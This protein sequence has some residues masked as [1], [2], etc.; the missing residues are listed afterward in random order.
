MPLGGPCRTRSR[1][2]RVPMLGVAGPLPAEPWRARSAPRHSRT[3]SPAIAP[4]F[5]SPGSAGL[6][7][8]GV[9]GALGPA[10]RGSPNR[11]LRPS[12]GDRL[13]GTRPAPAPSPPGGKQQARAPSRLSGNF[14][15]LGREEGLVRRSQSLGAWKEAAPSSDPP[16]RDA[17]PA[18]ELRAGCGAPGAVPALQLYRACHLGSRV[19]GR[20]T[21]PPSLRAQGKTIP[22]PSGQKQPRDSGSRMNLGRDHTGSEGFVFRC[23]HACSFGFPHPPILADPR[24][25][26]PGSAFWRPISVIWWTPP[27]LGPREDICP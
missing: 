8:R 22:R 23:S 1:S 25:T 6:W 2:F 15:H 18:C 4:E 24:N 5:Y 7:V 16:V 13:W 14:L 3:H 21:A 27:L 11:M 12:P 17:L 9:F 20:T 10:A 26:F 19:Q